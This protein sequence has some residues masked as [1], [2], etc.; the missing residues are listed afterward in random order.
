MESI[1]IKQG[2]VI[3]VLLEK[4]RNYGIID[5]KMPDLGRNDLQRNAGE[6]KMKKI[7]DLITAEITQAFVDCGYDAKYGKVTLSNR[8]DLCEYQ[9][10]GAMAAAKEYKKAPK[11][12]TVVLTLTVRKNIMA[13]NQIGTKMYTYKMCN[14]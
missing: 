12:C 8:P 3:R 10:N 2:I 6:K 14:F 5:E 13:L 9:C 1:F 11:I 7:L 4:W